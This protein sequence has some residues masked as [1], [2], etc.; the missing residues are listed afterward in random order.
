MRFVTERRKRVELVS[1]HYE[2]GTELAGA[3]VCPRESRDRDYDREGVVT[4]NC[5]TVISMYER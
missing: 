4:T 3:W 5:Q 2:H 1:G